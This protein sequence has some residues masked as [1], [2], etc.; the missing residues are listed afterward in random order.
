MYAEV[1]GPRVLSVCRFFGG[2]ITSWQRTEK[3][4]AAVGGVPS[5]PHL[6][7]CGAD[8]VYD[9]VPELQRVVDY[10]RLVGLVVIREKDHDHFQPADWTPQ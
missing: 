7:G 9:E 6:A 1:F 3:H 8:V 4:N 10:C 2:S 5:S